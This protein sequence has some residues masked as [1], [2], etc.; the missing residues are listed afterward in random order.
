MKNLMKRILHCCF[1]ILFCVCNARAEDRVDLSQVQG[2]HNDFDPALYAKHFKKSIT[3][4]EWKAL[5]RGV[6]EKAGE[7]SDAYVVSFTSWPPRTREGTP[8]IW[9][10]IETL[11]CQTHKA[12]RIILWLSRKEYPNELKDLPQTLIDLQSRGLEIVFVENNYKPAKKL[13]HALQANLKSNIITADDDVLYPKDWL[14]RF[15][16]G[17][18]EHPNT[19]LALVTHRM[20]VVDGVLQPYSHFSPHTTGQ[21]LCDNL[22][23]AI[24]FGGVLYPY[25]ESGS[26]CN[27]LDKR[28]LDV[29]LIEEH[30]TKSDDPWFFACRV[31]A[32]TQL[33]SVAS[34]TKA[35]KDDITFLALDEP[36]WQEN[37]QNKRND[38]VIRALLQAFPELGP[39][40]GLDLSKT[41]CVAQN[42]KLSFWQRVKAWFGKGSAV[43]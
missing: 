23:M 6:K 11:M 26:T 18:Q 20:K 3:Y 10:T 31:L 39:K 33:A 32:G 14:S 9:I 19:I 2:N 17:H 13:V 37:V 30:A 15:V 21:R 38:K 5:P 22:D 34:P 42:A 41:Q 27:G 7:G 28:V 1:L 8:G 29:A 35:I 24:G 16:R 43:T 25:D 4:D 36:L 40:L 12:D